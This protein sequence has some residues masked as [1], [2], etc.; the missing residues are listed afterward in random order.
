MR[1]TVIGSAGGYP[2]PGVATSGYLIDHDE[3]RIWCD[4]GPGTVVG[5]PDRLDTVDAVVISHEH[6][7]HCLDLIALFHA[8]AYPLA[9][10]QGPLAVYAPRPVIDKVRAFVTPDQTGLMDRTFSLHPIGFDSMV[11]VGSI[12]ATFAEATHPVQTL[13][14]RFTAG[15]HS[16]AYTGDTGP[17]GDWTTV[18]GDAD[19]FLCEATFVGTRDDHPYPY[20]L[21]A[22]EAGQIAAAN[23]VDRLVLTHIPIHWDPARSLSE[24]ETHFDGDLGLAE[25]GA[26]FSI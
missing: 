3:T 8:L 26:S 7:D 23:G 20:H 16:I 19:L 14:M 10:P 4:I 17:A 22:F 11:E 13:A 6:P 25:P 24:A 21:N 18:A 2:A 12:R 1:L 9:P 15:G 5:F